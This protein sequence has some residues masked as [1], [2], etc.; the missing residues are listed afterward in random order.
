MQ[1]LRPVEGGGFVRK[2]GPLLSSCKDALEDQAS[3][4]VLIIDEINRGNFRAETA[5][6]RKSKLLL[7]PRQSRGSLQ[8]SLAKLA[9]LAN[10][11]P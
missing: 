8:T 5:D 3:P 11:T 7:P 9:K 6:S 10:E 1:G 2:D 4:Y